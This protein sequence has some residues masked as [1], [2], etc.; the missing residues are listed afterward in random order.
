VHH[1]IYLAD[2]SNTTT[3]KLPKEKKLKVEFSAKIK[4]EM[5]KLMKAIPTWKLTMAREIVRGYADH[6]DT[7]TR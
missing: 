2:A 1:L 6:V 5:K 3:F 4:K 7:D